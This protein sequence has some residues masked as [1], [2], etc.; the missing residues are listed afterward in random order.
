MIFVK[1]V[2]YNIKIKKKI[3]LPQLEIINLLSVYGYILF[4]FSPY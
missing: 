2:K 1:S 3:C 4:Y